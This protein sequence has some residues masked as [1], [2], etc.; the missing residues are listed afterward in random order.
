M[1][2]VEMDIDSSR[3]EFEPVAME[4]LVGHAELG[5]GIEWL[6][7][8]ASSSRC[9]ETHPGRPRRTTSAGRAL[10]NIT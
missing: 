6:L 4:G 9:I 5:A 2:P 7:R 1:H 10:L 8:A 3:P